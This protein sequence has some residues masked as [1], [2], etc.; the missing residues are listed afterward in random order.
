MKEALSSSA[1]SGLTK[2]T[3]R[4]ILEDAILHSHCREYFR[5]YIM[6]VNISFQFLF[7]F[8]NYINPE[9]ENSESM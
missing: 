6:R 8:E 2:A 9:V 3:R 7:Y 4:N 5:S 1:T